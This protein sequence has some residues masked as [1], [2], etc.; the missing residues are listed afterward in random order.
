MD[1]HAHP[2]IGP[3]FLLII[4]ISAG[5]VGVFAQDDDPVLTF[6]DSIQVWDISYTSLP[7]HP[8]IYPARDILDIERG[9]ITCWLRLLPDHDR[10]DHVILHS[11]DSRIVLYLDTFWN[12]ALERDLLRVAGR[13]IGNVQAPWPPIAMGNS[14]PEAS[15][16]VDDGSLEGSELQMA[17]HST[18]PLPEGEWHHVTLTWNGYPE[19]EAAIYLDGIRMALRPYDQRFNND[20]P[21]FDSFSVAYRPSH[22]PVT[23]RLD[24]TQESR[25]V[26]GSMLATEGGVDIADLRV[27]RVPLDPAQVRYVL[28]EQPS[29]KPLDRQAEESPSQ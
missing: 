11:S 5:S 16:L 29:A 25:L 19:G 18:A 27:Y 7:S 24:P 21:D 4:F 8:A 13:A 1:S 28:A 12:R 22:W 26:V 14:Y 10:G 17:F 3:A 20:L 2:A 9:S 15:I 6:T 23:A